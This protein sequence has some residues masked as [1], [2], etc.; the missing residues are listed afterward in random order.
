MAVAEELNFSRAAERLLVA[1]P[2]LSTQ[3]AQLEAELGVVLL[4]RNR[5]TVRLTTA[6][7]A[8]LE[9]VRQLLQN[10]QAAGERARRVA[11]GEEGK[12]SIAFFSAPTMIFLPELVRQFRSLVPGVSLKL[13]ELTPERQL[14]ALLDGEV[15]MGFTRT[16]PPGYPQLQSKLLFEERMLAVLPESHRWAGRSWLKLDQLAGEDFVLLERGEASSLYDQTIHACLTAGFSP[17]VLHS[18]NLMATVTFLVAAGQGI[19]L[20]P[21]GVQ[22]LRRQGLRYVPLRPTPAPVP[23]LMSWPT[24]T[25]S[26][27][28]ARF[29]ELVWERQDWIKRSFVG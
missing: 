3:I 26:P 4:E 21:E 2:A 5:R 13:W 27:A 14:P 16:L 20:V 22:N 10:S 28:C 6:G 24:Q 18:P 19:S 15:D 9:D 8:Y 25:D 23:L 7:Q 29:R 1:Q 17:R 12:L 11:R